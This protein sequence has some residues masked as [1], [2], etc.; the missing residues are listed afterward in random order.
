LKVLDVGCCGTLTSYEIIHE[1]KPDKIDNNYFDDNY[2]NDCSF[3][4]HN[5]RLV[6]YFYHPSLRG[7]G[8]EEVYSL[9]CKMLVEGKAFKR[10]KLAQ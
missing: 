8:K 5:K 9:L 2:G 3:W 7:K 1:W 4:I 10:L 6:L